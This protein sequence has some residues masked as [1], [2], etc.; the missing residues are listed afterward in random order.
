MLIL[1]TKLHIPQPRPNRV[2]RAGLIKKLNEGLQGKLTL[3]SAPAGSGKTTLLSEWVNGCE[4]KI[5]WLSLDSQDNDQG[6]FLAYLIAAFQ[7]ISPDFGNE[8]L[9]STNSPEPLPI[10]SILTLLINEIGSF[11]SDVIFVLDDYHL[12]HAEPIDNVLNFL[13][14][15]LPPQLHIVIAARKHPKLPIARLRSQNHLLS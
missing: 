11:S 15:H 7:T 4:Q 1:E 14:A 3:I 2:F 5:V 6:R 9:K 13:I 8:V 10:E 12:I